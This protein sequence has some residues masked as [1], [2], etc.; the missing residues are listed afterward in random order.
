MQSVEPVR[1]QVLF[2]PALIAVLD[3]YRRDA[4]GLPSRSEVIREAVRALA[5]RPTSTRRSRGKA[6]RKAG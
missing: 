1:V 3:A 2:D 6:S 4:D 5:S